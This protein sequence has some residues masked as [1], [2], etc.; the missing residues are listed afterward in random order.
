MAD[1]IE[2][3]DILV[4]G[5][6]LSGINTGHILREKLP[7][8]S[9]AILEGRETIGG[10][11]RFFRYPGFRSD[12][13]MTSFGLRWHPWKHRHKMASAAEIVEYMEEAV[14]AARLRDKI[15]FK[16]RILSCE[17]RTD[18]QTWRLEVDA[19]GSRKVLIANFVISC[20][21]YYSYDKAL[22]TVI[23]GLEDFQGDTI[24]PQWWPEDFDY[25]DKR[26]VVIGS[27]AT[28]ITIVPSLAEKAANVTMLQRSPSFVISR[29]TYSYLDSFLRFLLP[30]AWAHWLMWWKDVV[31]E[32][33]AT[34]MLLKFPGSSRRLI[35]G[36]MKAA[37]PKDIDVNVHFNPS[38]NP[39]QQRLCMCPDGDFFKA[40][41]RDNCEIVTDVIETVTEDGIL[42]KSGRKLEADAIVT[43]TG[44]HVQLFGG[45]TPRVDGQ[46]I[47]SGSQ[48]TWRGCM[49]ESLPNIAF[50]MG[51]VTT[52][53]TPGADVMA[54]TV[55]RIIKQME[56]T[57]ST[58]V[59]PVME[60][61]DEQPRK[62][63]VSATSSYFIKASDRLPKVTGKG[64]WYGRV[65]LAVDAW[66]WLFGSVTDGLLY[67]H[68]QSKKDL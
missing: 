28:A 19:D 4:L 17:W 43:A 26:I 33:V 35:M 10:T 54:R 67:N 31:A 57:G 60:N 61:R 25:S 44:L 14:D 45:L 23:P 68:G 12:S 53:W 41:H 49:L 16:H 32:V 22:E 5:A 24:H 18:E 66:A 56:K 8:R 42:L 3:H 1:P 46:P 65:N 58:S 62:L 11:W 21:G 2:H 6:G 59:M 39:F 52:S 47:N 15:R 50:V 36:S 34:E 55:V 7:H 29:P 13:Y 40:L 48:Y 64:P 27:G 38:Y 51:Y 37:L 9:F 63:V 20:L 30:L